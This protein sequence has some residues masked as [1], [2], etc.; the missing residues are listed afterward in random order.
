MRVKSRLHTGCLKKGYK[1]WHGILSP[2][3]EYFLLKIR[4]NDSCSSNAINLKLFNNN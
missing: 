4:I 3:L 1:L 2:E